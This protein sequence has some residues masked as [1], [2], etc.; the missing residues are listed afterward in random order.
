MIKAKSGLIEKFNQQE[1]QKKEEYL[2]IKNNMSLKLEP[3]I[4]VNQIPEV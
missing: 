1:L 4:L 2:R 3:I